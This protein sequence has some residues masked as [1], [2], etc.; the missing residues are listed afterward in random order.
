VDTSTVTLRIQRVFDCPRDL[1][2]D[3]WTTPD[4]LTQWFAPHGT[5]LHVKRLDIRV[6]GS[7]H[8]CVRGPNFSDCWTVGTYTEL[9]RPERIVFTMA[10]A[11][12]DGRLSSSASQG[13]DPQWPAESVVTVTFVE[14]HGRTVMTL[15]QNVDEALAKRTGAHAGWQEMLDRLAAQLT[16]QS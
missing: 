1:V 3:A 7:F 4:L 5:T 16:S 11:D 9:L 6:G 10:I 15:E 8:W 13:H 2:F 14:Q 12:A